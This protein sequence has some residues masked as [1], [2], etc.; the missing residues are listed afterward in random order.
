MSAGLANLKIYRQKEIGN[1]NRLRVV[2]ADRLKKA[3]ADTR[4]IDKVPGLGSLVTVYF[5]EKEL[6]TARDV[7]LGFMSY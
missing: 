1:L 4:V 3:M 5:T 6:K 7:V 2:F